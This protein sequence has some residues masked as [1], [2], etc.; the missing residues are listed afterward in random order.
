M[1]ISK[2]NQVIKQQAVQRQQIPTSM[3]KDETKN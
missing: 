3:K 2:L 1:F